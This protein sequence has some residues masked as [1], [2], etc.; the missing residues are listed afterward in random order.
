[1]KKMVC[2]AMALCLAALTLA[3][4][5]GK[6]KD[7]GNSSA[8]SGQTVSA[9]PTPTAEPQMAKALRVKAESGL[10]IRAQ[11]STDSEILDLAENGQR[12]ALMMEDAQNGWYQI[13]YEG[14]TAYV[15]AEYAE[16]IEVTLEEYNQLRGGSTS[17]GSSAT[18]ATPTPA[19][20]D[21][22]TSGTDSSSSSA[23][24]STPVSENPEDGE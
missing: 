9:A 19:P 17:E 14:K 23:P 6:D 18:E 10:N 4:C 7:D 11:A 2:L 22:P 24:T 1:M 3:G 21:N 15:S 13:I 8:A 5:G 20:G 16:V 12:L